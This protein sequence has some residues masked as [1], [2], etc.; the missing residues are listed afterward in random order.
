MEMGN[1]WALLEEV[2]HNGFMAGTTAMTTL[3]LLILVVAVRRILPKHMRDDTL[4]PR[5][6]TR[7]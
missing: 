6:R 4:P 1:F 7:R 3:T 2:T 5:Q